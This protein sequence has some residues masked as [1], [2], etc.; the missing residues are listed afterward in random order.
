MLE[1]G[2]SARSQ[3]HEGRKGEKRRRV[4]AEDSHGDLDTVCCHP[5]FEQY[6]HSKEILRAA[7]W[8]VHVSSTSPDG[9][10]QRQ[11][12]GFFIQWNKKEGRARILTSDYVGFCT[13]GKLCDPAPKIDVHLRN[14]DVVQGHV[15]FFDEH[16]RFALLEIS[17]SS[18]FEV[19][20]PSFGCSPCYRQKV[21]TLA[22]DKDLYLRLVHGTILRREEKHLLVLNCTLPPCSS[23]GPVIDHSGDLIGVSSNRAVC[24]ISTVLTCI[25]MWTR[26]RCILRPMLGMCLSTVELLDIVQLDKLWCKY[27][28]RNGFI[29]DEVT[30]DSS[31]EKLGIKEGDLEDFFLSIGLNFLRGVDT[32][33][34]FKLEV[35][36]LQGEVKRFISLPV[37]FPDASKY[38]AGMLLGPLC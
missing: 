31:A 14:E 25:E 33:N 27:D 30:P 17:M 38:S 18:S 11:C 21:F 9:R 5:G 32:I 24:S 37:Q 13:D 28:I 19:E 29:V 1:L 2:S 36:D 20:I 3:E 4:A 12:S 6:E 16:C 10:H 7:R 22:R 26:F 8:I 35:R 15:L 23:G 34:D